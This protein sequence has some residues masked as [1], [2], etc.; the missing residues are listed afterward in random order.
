ML[1]F[2]LQVYPAAVLT[3]SVTIANAGPS[4]TPVTFTAAVSA[5][6]ALLPATAYTYSLDAGNGAGLSLCAVLG[7]TSNSSTLAAA[8]LSNVSVVYGSLGAKTAALRIY[9]AADCGAG[10]S[11]SAATAIAAVGTATIQVC[12]QAT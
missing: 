2:T 12:K 4:T 7:T 9:A 6:L 3:P 5:A 10:A 11:A 8:A 1:P